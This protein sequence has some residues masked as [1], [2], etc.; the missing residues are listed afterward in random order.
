MSD[1][2]FKIIRG[3]DKQIF[4]RITSA[5]TG[6]PKDL[7]SASAIEVIFDKT[8][9]SKLVL[10]NVNMPATNAK[11]TV[12]NII[13]SSATAG[14]S[15]NIIKLTADG[16]KTVSTVISDWNTVNPSN[17]V[18]SNATTDQ[19]ASVMPEGQYSLTGA[20]LSYMPVSVFGNALLGM[21]KVTLLEK[22][23]QSLK[24]GNNQSF[25]V[26]VDDGVNPSGLRFIGLFENKLDVVDN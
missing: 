9:N 6:G 2:R 18:T 26:K 1:T 12:A 14:S 19:L 23:T 5:K 10:A 4:I 21:V 22:E 16:V 8:N 13:F 20:Y 7:S 24:L 3:A 11:I 15:G 17:Q 25:S